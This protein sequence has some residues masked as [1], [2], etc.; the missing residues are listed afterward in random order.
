MARVSPAAAAARPAAASARPA[1]APL[2]TAAMP[3]SDEEF[4]YEIEAAA[5]SPGPAMLR[6]IDALTPRAWEIR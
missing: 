2:R 3:P 4:L 5:G 1:A 6:R